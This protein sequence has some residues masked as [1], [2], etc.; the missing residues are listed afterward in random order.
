MIEVIVRILF[1][2]GFLIGAIGGVVSYEY[3]K[4]KEKNDG[5]LIV[6]IGEAVDMI[7]IMLCMVGVCWVW[8]W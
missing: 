3:F 7:F 1:F 6:F 8:I 4:K 2:I 5:R